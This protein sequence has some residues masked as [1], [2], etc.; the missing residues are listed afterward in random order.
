M[1]LVI[2][3]GGGHGAVVTESARTAGRLVVRGFLD[4]D[5]SRRG[6]GGLVHCGLIE[7]AWTRPGGAEGVALGVGVS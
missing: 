1:R 5:P 7:A 2:L 4:D 6:V 3:G